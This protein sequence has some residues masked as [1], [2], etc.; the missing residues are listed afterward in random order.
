MTPLPDTLSWPTGLALPSHYLSL[1]S[2]TLSLEQSGIR[3]CIMDVAVSS[4][5]TGPHLFPL[6]PQPQGEAQ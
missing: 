1:K 6:S 2:P 5:R 3:A 4:L